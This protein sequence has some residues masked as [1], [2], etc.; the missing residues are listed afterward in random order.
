MDIWFNE[1]ANNWNEAIP[2]GNGHIAGMIFGGTIDD[3]IQLNDETLWYR[4]KCDRNNP[5]SYKYLD[6]I[7]ELLKIGKVNEAEDLVKLTMFAT[8]RDQSHYESLGELYINHVESQEPHNH[9]RGLS[10]SDAV[11]RTTYDIEDVQYTR[12]YFTSFNSNLLFIRMKSSKKGSINVNI[13]LGRQKRFSDIIEKYENDGIIMCGSAGGIKGVAFNVGCRV[14]N[15]DGESEVLGET[16]IVRNASEF[17]LCLTSVTD[18]WESDL[19]INL[20]CKKIL[21]EMSFHDYD[22]EIEK[23]KENYKRQFDRVSLKLGDEQNNINNTKERLESFK[24]NANDLGLIKTM[25]DYGRYLLICSSQPNGL[26]SNL[27][28]IWCEDLNPIWGSKYTININ[29]EMNYWMTGPCDL[30]EVEIPLFEMM[31]KMREPGRITAKK[32]YGVNGVTA[33]HNTDGFFDTAPQSHAIGAAVWP[34]TLPWLC[35]HIW[36]YY[37]YFQDIS[38]LEKYYPLIKE[39][40]QFYEGYLFEYD[41]YLVTGPSVSPENKFITENGVIGN[42]CLSPTIDNQI[43]RMF[44]NCYLDICEVLDIDRDHCKNVKD[45]LAKLPPTKV[46]KHGQIQE[47]L[48][49]YDEVE[50]GHRHISPLFGLHPGNEIDLDKTPVLAKA[51]L[52]T[53]ERRTSYGKYLDV[54]NREEAINS[55]QTAGLF[56]STRTGW[57]SAWLVHFYARLKKG[58]QGFNELVGMIKNTTLPNLF[59]DHPPFQIDGN[60]GFVSGLCELLIQSHNNK[61][62]ILPA[63]PSEVP[64][65]EF[66]GFRVRGGEKFSVKW[67]DNMV[68]RVYIKGEPEKKITFSIDKEKMKC[69]KDTVIEIEL[70]ENGE[71]EVTF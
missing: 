71:T 1:K 22:L 30:P 41:N 53:I 61:I 7:R 28:G 19:D 13:N 23:H 24:K 25:F 43:L 57:S 33:H 9:C 20:E 12:E 5:D 52:K 65:G 49:D 38:I 29:T 45:I 16:I 17:T 69:G 62:K 67:K 56:E 18:Y 48:V 55:W 63:I 14:I 37:N 8:P 36:E 59:S 51:A 6:K 44:F 31:N 50:I 64:S 39:V 70:D 60:L 3:K 40:V 21:K 68:E 4:G 11:A 26:P 27:Q 32:M 66:V 54:K 42:V 10:L 34:M 46:G 2:I 15:T 58:Q 47:W 35:T